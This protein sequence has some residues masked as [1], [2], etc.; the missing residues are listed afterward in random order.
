MP[1]CGADIKLMRAARG[2]TQAQ[3]C[4]ATGVSPYVLANME[5]GSN[6][7]LDDLLVV[8]GYLGMPLAKA[9]QHPRRGAAWSTGREAH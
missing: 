7:R 1:T 5:Q 4:L 8:V 6:P 2:L 9:V 3:V